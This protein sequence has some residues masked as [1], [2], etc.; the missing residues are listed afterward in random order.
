MNLK[1]LAIFL[2]FFNFYE[3]KMKGLIVQIQSRMTIMTLHTC[4]K[5]QKDNSY[6][7]LKKKNHVVYLNDYDLIT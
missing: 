2:F 6:K 1:I 4:I 7:N 5:V 3:P